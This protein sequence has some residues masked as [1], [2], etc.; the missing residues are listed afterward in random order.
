MDLL[1]L[2]LV[3]NG[4]SNNGLREIVFVHGR[5]LQCVFR[6][7]KHGCNGNLSF[8]EPLKPGEI[9]YL[10]KQHHFFMDQRCSG[11]LNSYHAPSCVLRKDMSS[12][13]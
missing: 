2:D 1:V 3:L 9:R 13:K 12:I 10:Q 11:C 7:L 5:R 6:I 4:G 8:S